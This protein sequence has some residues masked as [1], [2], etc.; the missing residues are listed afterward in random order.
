MS[1]ALHR[2]PGVDTRYYIQ[3]RLQRL[4]ESDGS[5]LGS[6][7]RLILE[8]EK[9]VIS[10]Q[11]IEAFRLMQ[12][13]WETLAEGTPDLANVESTGILL[14][15]AISRIDCAFNKL[16]GINP[17]SVW[18]LR[19]FAQHII[20]I[21]NVSTKALDML[22]K[23]DRLE[24]TMN[25]QRMH[26]V[27]VEFG[28]RTT[29]S[30]FF[31]S[32]S[33]VLT[34]SGAVRNVGEIL[35][36]S[37]AACRMMGHSQSSLVGQNINIIVP[38]PLKESHDD[39]MMRFR[40]K[41]KSSVI[42]HRRLLFAQLADHSIAPIWLA[43]GEAPPDPVTADPRLVGVMDPVPSLDAFMFVGG[44]ETNFRVYCASHRALDVLGL[45][46][47]TLMHEHVQATSFLP[48]MQSDFVSEKV[49]L[50]PDLLASISRVCKQC[51]MWDVLRLRKRP[52]RSKRSKRKSRRKSIPMD[53][54]SHND[55]AASATMASAIAE[56]SNIDSGVHP[57]D[58]DREP[59]TQG[60]LGP[61]QVSDWKASLE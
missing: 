3:E 13:L 54:T 12:N 46:G 21:K 49:W 36:A 16:L 20:S 60:M 27:Q 1:Q 34:V 45:E 44:P 47:E 17:Q 8:H 26:H 48:S 57:Q 5:G 29:D 15:Q 39:V 40:H 7:E 2:S 55:N 32:S 43:F 35:S 30:S 50:S 18:T 51:D 6:V 61:G 41:R 33:A 9:K 38:P 24:E 14:Q 37:T 59:R 28:L 19:N 25:R 4:N 22:A 56:E 23:A 42:G 10:R 31:G 58:S 11:R 53:S 52:K